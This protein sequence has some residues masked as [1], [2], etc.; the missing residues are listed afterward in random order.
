MHMGKMFEFTL[1]KQIQKNYSL[2]PIVLC[3]AFGLSLSGFAI[4]RTAFKSPDISVNRRGNPKPY[5]RYMTEDG[6]PLQYKYFSTLD[7]SK[8][9]PSERPNYN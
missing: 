6:R 7:Y 1:G 4:M 9:P 5:E 3:G 2:L 8:L